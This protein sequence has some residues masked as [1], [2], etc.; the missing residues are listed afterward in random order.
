MAYFHKFSGKIRP[1]SDG[2]LKKLENDFQEEL[3]KRIYFAGEN[4][5]HP[6]IEETE[7]Y[8]RFII[9]RL[10]W[11]DTGSLSPHEEVRPLHL[12]DNPGRA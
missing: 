1:L 6:P 12:Q 10:S 2:E 3:A 9:A 7:A 8:R 5:N 11:K 4:E